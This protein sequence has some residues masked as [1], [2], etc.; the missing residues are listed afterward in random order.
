[1]LILFIYLVIIIQKRSAFLRDILKKDRKIPEN[2][3][4]GFPE[5][6]LSSLR[7]IHTDFQNHSRSRKAVPHLNA[8]SFT[9][10][11]FFDPNGLNLQRII[12]SSLQNIPDTTV[13]TSFSR[14]VFF[15]FT[16]AQAGW[17]EPLTVYRP[18]ASGAAQ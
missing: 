5:A 6:F 7:Y 14:T 3:I 13:S 16:N 12:R 9:P 17:A 1:M 4:T 10:P 15:C 8:F 18:P 2:T 11:D